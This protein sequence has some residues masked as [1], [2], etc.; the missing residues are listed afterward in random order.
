MI[1]RNNFIG[2]LGL[3]CLSISGQLQA[4]EK[5][6]AKSDTSA[7]TVATNDYCYTEPAY[8]GI[9]VYEMGLCTSAPTAPTATAAA[10]TSSCERVFQSTSG[11]LVEVQNGKTSEPAGTFFRPANGTYTHAYMRLNNTFHIQ[12]NIDFGAAH[13]NFAPNRYCSSNAGSAD[14]STGGLA[15]TCYATAAAALAGM[16]TTNT[17]LVDF[18]GAGGGNINTATVGTLTAYLLKDNQFLVGAGEFSQAGAGGIL[19]VT[20]FAT[21]ITVTDESAALDAA[22][23]VSQGTTVSVSAGPVVKIDSGP[24]ALVLSVQ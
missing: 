23:T 6:C 17:E 7:L 19:G 15:G 22:I 4:A 20:K 12:A 3:L 16:A 2:F 9:T 21:A 18:D 5:T 14:N 11:A 1:T 24:F 10:G 13:G 8:Y